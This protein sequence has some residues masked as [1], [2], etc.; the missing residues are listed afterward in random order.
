MLNMKNILFKLLLII[1]LLGLRFSAQAS[2]KITGNLP[3]YKG[4]KFHIRNLES[5]LNEYH[6]NLLDQGIIDENGNFESLLKVSKTGEAILYIDQTFFRLWIGEGS[7]AISSSG[8]KLDFKGTLAGENRFLYNA[9]FMQPYL[10]PSPLAYKP[11]QLDE[12][13]SKWSSLQDERLKRLEEEK[14]N[15]LP[16]DFVSRMRSE[17]LNSTMYAKN[18]FPSL[19]GITTDT[20]PKDYFGFWD[21]FHILDDDPNQ[22]AYMNA[23]LDYAEFKA[24]KNH[25]QAMEDRAMLI[26]HEVAFLDSILSERPKT[27]E[28]IKGELAL[29]L[30][31]YFDDKILLEELIKSFRAD[32]PIS[33]YVTVIDK[34]WSEKTSRQN[35]KISFT[36][37]D[38]SGNEVSTDEFLGKVV[39]VDFWGSWCKACLEEMPA[40]A[41]LREKF[42]GRDVV[43][44]YL[45]FYDSKSQWLNAIKLH[46]INGINLKAEAR[47]L[48]YFNDFFGVSQGFPRYAVIDR[49]GILKTT[50]APAPSDKSVIEFLEKILKG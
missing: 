21:G 36:L 40:A 50:G 47:D 42:E 10:I 5:A 3:V 4:A 16:A 32:Y 29:F 7:L 24:K 26:R 25:P 13:I 6:G 23:L 38:T 19:Q 1:V 8:S 28:A 2:C 20:L 37:R 27:L 9:K 31:K 33:P 41:K 11:S 43:F 45:D 12:Y 49:N 15:G 39:Y 14:K 46:S 35:K 17:I 34:K 30:I 48:P 22:R 44:L 18:Q